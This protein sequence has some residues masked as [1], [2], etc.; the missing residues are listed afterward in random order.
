MTSFGFVVKSLLL[1][2]EE[3]IERNTALLRDQDALTYLG[4]DDELL[5]AVA[6]V[7]RLLQNRR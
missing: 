4:V 3:V 2:P 5:L 1:V 6:E 7:E